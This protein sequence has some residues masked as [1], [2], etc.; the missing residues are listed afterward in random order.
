MNMPHCP[1]CGKEVSKAS[2]T[3]EN[4]SFNIQTYYCHKCHQS[5]QV[6]I[7]QSTH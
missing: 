3:L 6:G 1:S 7:Y 5:F 4:Y 2:K